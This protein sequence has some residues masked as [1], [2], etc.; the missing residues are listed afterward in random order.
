MTTWDDL[1][2]PGEAK[3]FFNPPPLP[4]T[5]FNGAVTEYND[6][7]AW[8]LM[9]LSRLVYCNDKGKRVAALGRAG[10]E[11]IEFI[12]TKDDPSQSTK[13]TQ[14]FVVAP[15]E[16]A[17]WAALVFRGTEDLRDWLTNAQVRMGPWSLG[18]HE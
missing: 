1:F 4:S 5:P 12:D 11:E 9:E 7:N 13:D 2:K 6:V 16:N 17:A 8:W 14:C 15:R 18:G 10:L 3:D